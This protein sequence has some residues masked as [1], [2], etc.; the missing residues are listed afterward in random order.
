MNSEYC[1]C[2]C[3]CCV[4]V[5]VQACK[6]GTES[7]WYS[8]KHQG[9]KLQHKYRTGE[10]SSNRG[11]KG[12]FKREGDR[13]FAASG[14]RQTT[15]WLLLLDPDKEGGSRS[16]TEGPMS[17]SGCG[18]HWPAYISLSKRQ[19]IWVCSFTDQKRKSSAAPFLH[20]SGCQVKICSGVIAWVQSNESVCQSQLES[21]RS[22]GSWHWTG[23]SPS[24][25]D[26][27]L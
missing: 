3:C 12:S 22:T 21:V 6:C 27:S 11:S 4:Q 20:S 9:L 13:A 1:C 24:T 15:D 19:L 2:C 16:V 14:P 5:Q 25:T 23:A 17:G 8:C 10:G 18:A 26:D 7:Q